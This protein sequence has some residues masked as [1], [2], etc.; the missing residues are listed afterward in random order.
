MNL[1]MQVPMNTH[2]L[3][4]F[5]APQPEEEAGRRRKR[6]GRERLRLRHRCID[7]SRLYRRSYRLHRARLLHLCRR[8]L[9]GMGEGAGGQMRVICG[10]KI[11]IIMVLC[12]IS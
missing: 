9:P 11:L 3:H 6:A 1:C 10:L 5:L 4:E 8:D 2:H 7:V 12:F